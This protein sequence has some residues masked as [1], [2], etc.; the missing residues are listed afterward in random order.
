M[1]SRVI[2]VI[3][4]LGVR[5]SRFQFVILPR[6]SPHTEHPCS[7][8]V[9]FVSALECSHKVLRDIS[10]APLIKVRDENSHHRGVY[11]VNVETI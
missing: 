2:I 7:C 10:T 4:W 3:V 1:K 11:D 5:I 6:L 9:K 8:N